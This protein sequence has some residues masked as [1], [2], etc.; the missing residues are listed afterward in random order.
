MY[1]EYDGYDPYLLDG[2][3]WSKRRDTEPN[4]AMRQ[5]TEVLL[6]TSQ[7]ILTDLWKKTR[8]FSPGNSISIYSLDFTSLLSSL[9]FSLWKS[10]D[11]FPN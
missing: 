4:W 3:T 2:V 11:F 1:K 9:S 10:L 6:W 8:V 7:E 5:S